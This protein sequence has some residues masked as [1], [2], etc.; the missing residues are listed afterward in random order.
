M[1]Q[2]LQLLQLHGAPPLGLT[3]L[4]SILGMRFPWWRQRRLP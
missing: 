3:K 2:L 4:T 1:V